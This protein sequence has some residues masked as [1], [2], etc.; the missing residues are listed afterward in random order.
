MNVSDYG[1]FNKD[2]FDN[3]NDKLDPKIAAKI[4]RRKPLTQAEKVRLGKNIEALEHTS[5]K[6]LTNKTAGL[7]STDRKNEADLQRAEKFIQ[8]KQ[9]LQERRLQENLRSADLDP[10]APE[11]AEVLSHIQEHASGE[12]FLHD[13]AELAELI[14][15]ADPDKATQVFAN[16]FSAPLEEIQQTRRKES[17]SS[18]AIHLFNLQM[19]EEDSA[20]AKNITNEKKDFVLEELNLD[21][22]AVFASQARHY[23]L[24]RAAVLEIRKNLEQWDHSLSLDQLQADLRVQFKNLEKL[25]GIISEFENHPDQKAAL[26]QLVH[27]TKAPMSP[28]D[29]LFADYLKGKKAL[30][31]EVDAAPFVQAMQEN[32][33][34]L[35]EEAPQARSKDELE[36]MR[37][38]APMT[39]DAIRLQATLLEKMAGAKDW[40]QDHGTP[41]RSESHNPVYKVGESYFKAGYMIAREMSEEEV[42][43]E[44]ILEEYTYVVGT[45]EESPIEKIRRLEKER[46]KYIYDSGIME[47]L[48]WDVA[49]VM[50]MEAHFTPTGVAEVG[51]LRKGGIQPAL[52]GTLFKN[53]S[54]KE[55]LKRSEIAKAVLISAI[56]GS[57]DLH[58]SNIFVEEDGSIKYFDN[59]KSLPSSN[60][61]VDQ[62][63]ALV[64]CFRNALLNLEQCRETLS[65]EEIQQLLS[66][67]TRYEG[68]VQDLKNYLNSSQARAA[69]NQLPPGW[70]DGDA[71]VAALEDRIALLKATLQGGQ[72]STIEQL[73]TK[74][75][76]H[77]KF[78]FAMVYLYM[79][80]TNNM[81]NIHWQVPSETILKRFHEYIGGR[82]TDFCISFLARKGYNI[83]LVKEWCENPNSNM[84]DVVELIQM[85]FIRPPF[86]PPVDP[87]ALAERKQAGA[88]LAEK[89]LDEALPDYKDNSR[90]DSEFAWRHYDIK[91]N[92]VK[93]LG[94]LKIRKFGV[95]RLNLEQAIQIVRNQRWQNKCLLKVN[96][97][98]YLLTKQDGEIK[99]QK[100]DFTKKPGFVIVDGQPIRI[101]DLDK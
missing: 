77:Y 62:C 46:F 13:I 95:H 83:P 35:K 74:S 89:L 43:L 63:G 68:K 47:K 23:P 22:A 32:L 15:A 42:E 27:S 79:I 52:Q 78:A 44:E 66:D 50:G 64:P 12:A 14:K 58:G 97:E 91:D 11:F 56:F 100:M 29:T 67:L 48:M 8:I 45:Q 16:V 33:E 101:S 75:L 34:R 70:F 38:Q 54:D 72:V 19:T 18:L 85:N 39:K 7:F 99:A 20:A 5:L 88:S 17:L 87:Q 31:D 92:N 76:P 90:E 36:A 4:E 28:F 41:P 84:K 93:R 1:N 86:T 82:S 26:Y 3:F 21:K 51:K 69:I 57:F 55:G 71:S 61:F 59:S 96:N 80:E 49:V 25:S 24:M 53:Y 65:A 81:E 37:K 10:T 94:P 40:M 30:S 9:K 60:G 73:I 98:Y 2:R 6:W